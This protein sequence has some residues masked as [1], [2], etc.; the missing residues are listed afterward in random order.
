MWP[1]PTCPQ[2]LDGHVEFGEP[3]TIQ[4][5]E[6]SRWQLEMH[7]NWEPEH[8]FGDFHVRAGCSNQACGQGFLGLGSYQIER[9]EEAD[10]ARSGGW[11]EFYSLMYITPP[12]LLMTLPK[13][14]PQPV[15]DGVTRAASLI[16]ADPSSAANALRATVERYLT[17]EGIS[18]AD[19]N[20]KHVPAHHR[21]EAW[22]QQTGNSQVQD[23]LMAVK[24]I[25]NDGS[26]EEAT[27]TTKQ[28]VDGTQ[29][30]ERAFHLLFDTS[31]DDLDARA[32][33]VNAHK[34]HPGT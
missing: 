8:I 29:F 31:G 23:L 9:A 21:I 19:Q 1:R 10:P 4:N 33:A 24:W 16:L 14:T 15:Q 28:V 22:K 3:T 17:T 34:G 27:L 20:G 26:H 25:G 5:S 12:L 7:D 6:S 2:C 11:S 13:D 32:R 30:L 18:S